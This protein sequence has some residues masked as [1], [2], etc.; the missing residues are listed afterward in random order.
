MRGARKRKKRGFGIAHAKKLGNWNY[1]RARRGR[2]GNGRKRVV[3]RWN[4]GGTVAK[5][6][7]KVPRRPP[8]RIEL[9]ENANLIRR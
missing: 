7:G 9:G 6:G 5:K 3:P 2:K 8:A 4:D 1:H